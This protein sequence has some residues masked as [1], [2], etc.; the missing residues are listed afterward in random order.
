[1]SCE[2]AEINMFYIPELGASPLWASNV[3]TFVN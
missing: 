1:M 3:D 2:T